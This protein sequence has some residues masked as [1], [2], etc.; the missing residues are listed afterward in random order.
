MKSIAAEISDIQSFVDG[1]TFTSPLSDASDKK[2]FAA[3]YKYVHALLIWEAALSNTITDKPNI[4]AKLHYQELLSDLAGSQLLLLGGLY[5]P[6]RMML[7]SSIENMLRVCAFEQGL[8]PLSK[9]FTYEMISLVKTSPL[10]ANGTFMSPDV[11][12]M[13]RSYTN[14]CAYVHAAA[15]T[16]MALRIPLVSVASYGRDEFRAVTTELKTLAYHYNRIMFALY[17]RHLDRVDYN[18]SD[19]IRDSLPKSIK[20]KF[21]AT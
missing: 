9:K 1:L 4:D 12:A 5:K 6:A 2:T 7:R 18:H 15:K 16:H 11:N 3:A 19:Y 8:Y 13:V 17:A 10:F 14:L 20:S 21:S